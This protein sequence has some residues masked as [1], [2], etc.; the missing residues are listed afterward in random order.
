MAGQGGAS[1][2][3]QIEVRSEAG[4]YRLQ[5]DVV[6]DADYGPVYRIATDYPGLQRLSGVIKRSYL[7]AA[8]GDALRRGLELQ[9][10]IL[11]F[12]K[13]AVLIED[14]HVDSAGE[15]IARVVPEQSDFDY[16]LSRLRIDGAGPGR[17]RVRLSS[18]LRPAFNVPPLV[19]A[20]IIK[21][22]L[23]QMALEICA[24]LE[25]LASHGSRR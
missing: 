9:A 2:L 22:K 16:G 19:G 18:A 20:W 3:R 15:F 10:C 1:E 11:F 12:C 8:A 17:T 5:L 21:R 14:V 4:D 7:I 25:A 23:R 24:N 13:S 6:V